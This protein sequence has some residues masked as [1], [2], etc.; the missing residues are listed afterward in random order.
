MDAKLSDLTM[1]KSSR[2]VTGIFLIFLKTPLASNKYGST[3]SVFFV[4]T[5]IVKLISGLPK[6]CRAVFMGITHI[7]SPPKP[8]LFPLLFK[9]PTTLYLP[10]PIFINSSIELFLPKRFFST[11]A[12]IK[13]ICELPFISER[14][15]FLPLPKSYPA[16]IR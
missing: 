9:T 16:V 6:Y 12:P 4:S 1:S 14:V 7:L 3:K 8:E 15:K 10:A 13:A 2:L 5:F 11:S